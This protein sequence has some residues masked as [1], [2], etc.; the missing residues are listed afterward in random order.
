MLFNNIVYI[1]YCVCRVGSELFQSQAKCAALAAGE[2]RILFKTEIA[3]PHELHMTLT[4]FCHASALI[5]HRKGYVLCRDLCNI[6]T[7]LRKQFHERKIFTRHAG[8]L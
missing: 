3:F 6:Q 1:V 7:I 5:D 4:I 2:G 8:R